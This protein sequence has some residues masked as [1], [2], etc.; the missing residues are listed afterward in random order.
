[1]LR[2]QAQHSLKTD[3][4]YQ[5]LL[6]QLDKVQMVI[7]DRWDLEVLKPCH[8][9][10]LMGIMDDCHNITSTLVPETKQYSLEACTITRTY[11]RAK[12]ARELFLA[13]NDFVKS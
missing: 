3:G 13:L 12:R 2:G 8:R 1:V 11:G 5:K 7:L 10:G 4:F 6:N 9:N